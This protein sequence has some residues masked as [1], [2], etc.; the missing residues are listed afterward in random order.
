MARAWR[1]GGGAILLV[2]AITTLVSCS[3]PGHYLRGL[4]SVE[5]VSY[6]RMFPAYAETT[7]VFPAAMFPL[8]DGEYSGRVTEYIPDFVIDSRGHVT[9][10]SGT[11]LN[12]AVR[13]DVYRGWKRVATAWAFKGE[14]PP[15]FRQKDLFAFKL[16][17]LESHDNPQNGQD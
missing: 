12:P 10:R 1:H 7:S 4:E 3:G 17:T 11:A 8:S 16:L 15:H 13:I 6:H 14:G 9:S 2:T 5:L